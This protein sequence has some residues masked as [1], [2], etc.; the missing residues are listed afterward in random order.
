M[1]KSATN[2][3]QFVLI[4]G[5][6]YTASHYVEILSCIKTCSVYKSVLRNPLQSGASEQNLWYSNS[7]NIIHMNSLRNYSNCTKKCSICTLDPCNQ[8]TGS[9]ILHLL[10]LLWSSTSFDNDNIIHHTGIIN[11]NVWRTEVMKDINISQEASVEWKPTP[12][13]VNTLEFKFI[14]WQWLYFLIA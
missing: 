2:L 9:N 10:S 8:M 13:T 7:N 1:L 4:R 6:N 14:S 3:V 11:A 12:I 5:L